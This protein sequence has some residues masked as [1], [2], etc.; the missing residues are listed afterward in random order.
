MKLIVTYSLFIFCCLIGTTCKTPY[1]PVEITVNVNYLV[2]EG[3]INSGPDSTIIKLSRTTKLKDKVQTIPERG[4][5]VVVE[6]DG[7]D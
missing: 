6:S 3:I 2:V 5:T 1:E 7:N 4:A